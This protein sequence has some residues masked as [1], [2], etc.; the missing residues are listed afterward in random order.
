MYLLRVATSISTL[1]HTNLLDVFNERDRDRR[2]SVIDR[3]HAEDVVFHDPEGTLVGRAALDDKVQ[4]LLDGALGWVFRPA[5]PVRESRGLGLLAWEFGP[6]GQPPVV[7]GIDIAL[8]D[9]GGRIA[10]LHTM[11]TATPEAG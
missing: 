5:G 10:T 7:T 8:V 2:H 1:M 4:G 6:E 9:D 3:I 11:L